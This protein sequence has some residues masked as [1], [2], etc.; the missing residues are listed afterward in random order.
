MVNIKTIN[1][2]NKDKNIRKKFLKI[3]I[4][5][6]IL[7]SLIYNNNYPF[8]FKYYFDKIFKKIL[9]NL[10]ISKFRTYCIFLGNS[11]SIFRRFKLSRHVCKKYSSNGFIIGLKKS[12]F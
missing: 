12:S 10:S 5:K 7:K 11:K 1:Y 3:E 6:L 2:I 4:N 9:F 8:F